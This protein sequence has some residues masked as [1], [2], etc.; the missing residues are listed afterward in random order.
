MYEKG[1][2]Y[3]LK[4]ANGLPNGGYGQSYWVPWVF[5]F[6]SIFKRFKWLKSHVFD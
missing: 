1:G 4:K 2:T 5:P 6:T 3:I